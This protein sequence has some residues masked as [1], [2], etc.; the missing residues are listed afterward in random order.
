MNRLGLM[1]CLVMAGVGF[2]LGARFAR[3][4]HTAASSRSSSGD[5]AALSPE[6][7]ANAK[8]AT[9]DEMMSAV[10]TA[11]TEEDAMAEVFAMEKALRG[12]TSDE[13]HDLFLRAI[14]VEHRS[15]CRSI[16]FPLMEHWAAIDPA[17]ATKAVRPFLDAARKSGDV[18][19]ESL[20]ETVIQAWARALPELAIAEAGTAMDLSLSYTLAYAA[21]RAGGDPL[22]H[23]ELMARLPDSSLRSVRC[24][25][26]LYELG[27]KDFAAAAARLD[28]LP[29]PWQRQQVFNALVRELSKNEPAAAFEKLI[30]LG[31]KLKDF[32]PYMIATVVSGMAES[33][34]TEALGAVDRLPAEYREQM[35]GAIVEG[36]AKKNPRAA[37]EWGA[38]RGINV[39][40][41]LATAFHAA[42]QPTLDWVRAQPASPARDGMLA[43]GILRGTYEQKL[44]AYAE[45]TP[46][47]RAMYSGDRVASTW[48]SDPQPTEAWVHGLPSG[49]ER[50]GAVETLTR[51]QADAAPEQ[52]DTLANMWS[53]GPDRDAAL[54]GLAIKLAP[55][56]PTRSFEFARWITDPT[57]REAAL[58]TAWTT[59]EPYNRSAARAWLAKSTNFSADHKRVL[60]RMTEER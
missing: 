7:G 3:G 57:R 24:S 54:R 1:V 5:T 30:A 46:Q 56:E 25:E 60:L 11:A 36:W 6:S 26:A 37:L 39:T 43:I 18:A 23:L 2:G 44:A 41:Q 32:N 14:K 48:K 21:D 42:Y 12:L 35:L 53:A 10:M 20:D 51:K 31:P 15:R 17:A 40:P 4:G 59:W 29:K 58:E 8:F 22:R 38:A 49:D 9:R 55:K 34:P 19:M 28:L 27:K 47:G 45:L 52:I 13:M 50:A 16:L 33:Q